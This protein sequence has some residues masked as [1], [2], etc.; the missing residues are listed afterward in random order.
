MDNLPV[1]LALHGIA[2]LGI[3]AA[4]GLVLWRVLLRDRDGADWHLVH[5]SGT[6]RGVFLLALAPATHLLTLP[7][8]LAVIAV[9]L[10]ILFT[11]ASLLAMFIRALSG[12]RGFYSGGSAANRVVFGLYAVGA[13]ALF[14]GTAILFVGFA[15]TL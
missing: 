11:W 12:Q 14:P 13:V 5:A 1:H 6:V 8:W 9:C 7:D 3:S 4:A 2:V 10:I 15:R